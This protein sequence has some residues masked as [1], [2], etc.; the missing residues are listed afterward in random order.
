MSHNKTKDAPKR[1]TAGRLW[2]SLS[3]VRRLT[4]FGT[5]SPINGILPTVTMTSDVI[6]ATIIKPDHNTAVRFKPKF[7]LTVSP[8]PKIVS[9][10]AIR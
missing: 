1:A 10:S 9:R 5:T 6:S 2:R 4:I 7:T 8:S 3:P